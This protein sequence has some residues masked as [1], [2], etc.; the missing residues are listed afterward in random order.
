M[1]SSEKRRKAI[2]VI[3]A[4]LGGTAVFVGCSWVALS[5]V[6]MLPLSAEGYWVFPIGALMI[7][8]SL[9]S[10]AFGSFVAYRIS[11]SIWPSVWVAL[12][13]MAL[14]AIIIVAPYLPLQ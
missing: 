13:T 10:G 1:E 3:A 12:L 8:A 6:G 9:I 7:V 4:A 2:V 11:R 5:V 14:V